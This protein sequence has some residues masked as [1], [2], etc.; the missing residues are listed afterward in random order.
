LTKKPVSKKAETADR[1]GKSPDLEAISTPVRLPIKQIA[2]DAKF[3]VRNKLN[4]GT[5][6]RYENNYRS[7][8]EMPPVKV[9][10]VKN[11]P[12]LVDGWHRL[13]ALENLGK[14]HVEAEVQK[15]TRR[16]AL[17]MAASANLDHGLPLK[18]RELRAVFRAY[19][20][21]DR[22]VLPTG[23]LK[24]YREIAADLGKPH[25]TIYNWMK[26][27]F[28]R[29][30]A[31]LSG[32]GGGIGGLPEEPL[33]AA[34]SHVAAARTAMAKLTA[35]FSG[36]SDAADRGMIIDE[37]ETALSQMRGSGNWNAPDY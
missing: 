26:K 23:N 14:A 21:A 35:A 32:D 20:R 13:R 15:A 30:A 5:V 11:V 29:V 33:D 6:K 10:L 36:T 24:S 34:S 18:Q 16:E 31:Q 2:R 8:R 28:P 17:W 4:E 37:L 25:G 19:I 1:S 22:H 27:D 7:G 12:I 9:A 3:Q